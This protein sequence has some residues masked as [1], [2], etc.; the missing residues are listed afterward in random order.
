MGLTPSTLIVNVL[1]RNE[2]I[3]PLRSAFSFTFFVCHA[4]K[5]RGSVFAEVLRR[6]ECLVS[7]RKLNV[8]EADV[9]EEGLI[10]KEMTVA[11]P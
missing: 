11:E 6:S 4:F 3:F 9:E 1:Y 8:F 10:Y 5:L 2:F 7:N